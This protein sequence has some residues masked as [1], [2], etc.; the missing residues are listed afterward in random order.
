MCLTGPTLAEEPGAPAPALYYLGASRVM[1][2]DPS[3]GRPVVLVD[4][5]AQAVRGSVNDGIAIDFVRGHIYW[6]N[7]GRASEDDGYIMR[8]DLDGGGLTMVV[9]PGGAYTPKQLKIDLEGGN[10]TG[11]TAREW[12]S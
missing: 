11:R 12:P 7:M 10:S 6:T 3:R 9:P 8:S 2:V 4:Q 1:T 5:T